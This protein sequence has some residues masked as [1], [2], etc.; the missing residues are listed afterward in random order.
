MPVISARLMRQDFFTF[1]PAFKL[2]I[3]GNHKPRVGRVDEAIR[4]RFNLVPFNVTIPPA[5]RD[6]LLP[7]KLRAEWPGILQWAIDGCLIWQQFDGLEPPAAVRDATEEYLASQDLIA[8]WRD[9]CCVSGAGLSAPRTAL[10]ASWKSWAEAAGEPPGKMA[11]FYEVLG[12]DF[13]PARETRD[14]GPVG[15]GTR[16]FLCLGLRQNRQ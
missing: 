7:E 1:T 13:Q 12:R 3:A 15:K 2:V 5:Q 9:E 4:R 10:F 11:E 6:L 16:L 14:G 8:Q